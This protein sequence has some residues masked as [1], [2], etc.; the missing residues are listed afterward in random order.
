MLGKRG[1]KRS[2]LGPK[3][4]VCAMRLIWSRISMMSP[5]LKAGFMPPDALDT[6]SV[7]TPM[8]FMTYIGNT[9]SFIV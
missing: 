5:T 1:P 6:N 3:S 4:G 9:T 2:S 7:R 8:Y